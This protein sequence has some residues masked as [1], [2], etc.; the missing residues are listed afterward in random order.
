MK[1]PFAYYGGKQNLVSRILPLIPLHEQYVEPFI[2]GG[3]VYWHKPPSF[4][5]CIN[6]QDHM[7]VNFYEVCK[8]YFKPLQ[9]LVQNTLHSEA[10]H[11]KAKLILRNPKASPVMRAWAFWLQCDLSFSKKIFGG[12]AFCNDGGT[13]RGF[14]NRKTN[15]V[16]QFTERLENTEIFCRDALNLFKLK[17][18]PKT[19]FYLDPPYFNSDCGHYDGYTELDFQNLLQKCEKCEGKFILSSYNSEI[20]QKF[21]LRNG[22]QQIFIEQ[23]VAVNPMQNTGKR[24]IEVLTFN[25]TEGTNLK[26]F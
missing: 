5:E 18:S 8:F 3:A 19:F 25:F 12:F 4:H 13:N 20:L 23:P 21:V 14:R 10:Q 7:V 16:D 26:L 15:F 2:G 11:S 24:K 17:D 6:D 9:R 22:W 1:P